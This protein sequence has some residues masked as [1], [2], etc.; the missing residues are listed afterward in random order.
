MK[1]AALVLVLA[2][3]GLP[4]NDL[5]RY[6]L[7]VIAAVL[8]FAG[9]LSAHLRRWFGAVAAVA[10]CVL[11]QFMLAAPRIE[12][13][14]NVFIVDGPGGA[15]EAGLPPA[16]FR[17]MRA[18][19]DARYPPERRCDPRADGCWRGQGFPDRPFAFSADGIFDHP[20]FSRRVTGIDFADPV[21]LRLGFINEL[22]YNWNSNVSDLERASRDRRFRVL[23]HRWKLEMPWFVMYRFPAEFVGSALC[24]RGD[25]LWE[26]AGSEFAGDQSS[27]DG[28]PD[29]DGG[30][31]RPAHLRGGDQARPA[32]RDAARADNEN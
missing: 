24:W 2:A 10:L 4:I 3:L 12:E 15:L 26:G 6:A 21:W 20:A 7:L 22:R 31:R 16:A 17:F 18:E 9:T 19:F 23:V 29:A 28:L 32:A 30:R 14:H 27:L 8:I 25:V 1:L 13:G 5:F 11:G